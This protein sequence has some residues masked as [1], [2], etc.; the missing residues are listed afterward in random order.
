MSCHEKGLPECIHNVFSR[1]YVCSSRAKLEWCKFGGRQKLNTNQDFD[2]M[3]E[4]PGEDGAA[5]NPDADVGA[6]ASELAIQGRFDEARDTAM[7]ALR[8]CA[9]QVTP[10]H[11]SY[12]RC[13][14]ALATVFRYRGDHTKAIDLL[15][16][17]ADSSWNVDNALLAQ[18][19]VGLAHAIHCA[20]ETESRPT[21]DDFN[22]LDTQQI[23]MV[24]D[25]AL[26]TADSSV[27]GNHYAVLADL[28]ERVPER[29][30]VAD[31]V[32]LRILCGF[33]NFLS[34]QTEFVSLRVSL[35]QTIVDAFQKHGDE[36]RKMEAMEGL[37]LAQ[38]EAGEL[39]EAEETYRDL[40]DQAHRAK[41][42]EIESDAR[43]NFG[44]FLR[45]L[46]RSKS[47][48]E[49]QLV[50][51]IKAGIAS[52]NHLPEGRARCA[53]GIHL[54]HIGNPQ[55]ARSHLARA[56]SILPKEHRDCILAENHLYAVDHNVPCAC[57]DPKA[58]VA[59][60]VEDYI[61]A[62]I[63]SDLLSGLHVSIDAAGGVDFGLEVTRSLSE[64]E[65]GLVQ[66]VTDE[67]LE[68]F[69]LQQ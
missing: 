4:S 60:A 5:I 24:I 38:C 62:R 6:K 30:G 46:R 55:K 53:Y 31:R 52:K 18:S 15:L 50:E 25:E 1:R 47:S 41:A 8:E 63:P 3:S 32:S 68:T 35:A 23:E 9:R 45:R 51:A 67:A 54:T 64:E 7:A 61:Q 49:E 37:A 13:Q 39:K 40:V 66:Q 29:L 16:M 2:K 34:G 27:P 33:A 12:I 43:R 56:V 48:L 36:R 28:S 20:G 10:D 22:R 58:E 17:A 59:K 26:A 14:L 69:S 11:P 42:Y 21:F 44:L 19:I 65:V 57:K